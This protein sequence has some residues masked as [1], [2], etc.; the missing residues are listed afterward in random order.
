MACERAHFKG[1]GS[2]HYRVAVVGN[3]NVGKSTLFTALTKEIAHIAN[4]PGTTVERKEGLIRVSGKEIVLIDLPGIYSLSGISAEERVARDFLLTGQWDALLILVDSLAIERTLYLAVHALE[5]TGRAVVALTKW[6]AAHKQGVHVSISKL[7]SELGI[8]VVPVSAVTREGIGEL[9]AKLLQVLEGGTKRP[10]K[11]EY[12]YLEKYISE[13]EKELANVSLPFKAPPRWVA[14]KLLEGDEHISMLVRSAGGEGVVRRAGELRSLIV[15]FTGREVDELEIQYRFNFVDELCKAAVVRKRVREE[16]GVFERVLLSRAGAAA[17]L[18]ILLPL[19]L[20]VFTFNTGFPLT[21][22]LRVVGAA[23]VAELLESST[24]S[25]LIS[26]AFDGVAALVRESS[27]PTVVKSA[28]ADGVLQGVG[29]VLTFL[30]LIFTALLILSLLEDSGIGPYA[31]ASL[32]RFFQRLGLSGRAVYPLLISLGCNVPAV[33]AS[34]TA[35]DEV[36]RRQLVFSVPFIPCQARLVIIVAFVSV[37]FPSPFVAV[38][39]LLVTYAAAFALFAFTSTIIRRFYGIR[40]PPELLIELPPIH[41]PSLRVLWWIA[42]DYTKHYLKRAGVV[43]FGLSLIIWALTSELGVFAAAIGDVLSPLLALIGI[44]G[45]KATLI[46]FSLVAG[47]AAK[48][49][50]LLSISA[51]MGADPIDAL[52]SLQLTGAQ[53]L[54]LLALYTTYMPCIATV[55]TIY[56]ETG[57]LKYTVSA[58]AWSLSLSLV[59]SYIVYILASGLNL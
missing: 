7:E 43:I 48:E 1:A 28:I 20:A 10:L 27:L 6:D 55:G 18:L 59:T 51:T 26:G 54:S 3:P 32:H 16:I 29:L 53:A 4:W 38:T 23:E 24:L 46:G 17:S 45:E 34:R 25:G 30:P 44:T 12:G 57:S 9:I 50:V 11:V 2:R 8:P 5:L 21:L 52:R 33:M 49:A 58:T 14:L 31:A 39:A 40:E 22:I 15:Q 13:L 42:W 35:P 37:Y 56:K 47:L 19:Y 36:E 41:F